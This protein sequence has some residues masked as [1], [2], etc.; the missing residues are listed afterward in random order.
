M[1]ELLEGFPDNAV[2]I[3]AKGKITRRDYETILIPKVKGS[4]AKRARIRVYYELGPEYTGFDAGAVWEDFM[5]GVEHLRGW[6]RI[7]VVTDV[8]WIRMAIRAFQF[9]IV[10]EIRCFDMKRVGEA[11]RWISEV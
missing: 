10:G 11:R 2:A 5:L 6:D 7:A 1:I 9:L 8:E 3:S 4:F